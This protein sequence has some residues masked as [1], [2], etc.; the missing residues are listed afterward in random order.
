MQS[1]RDILFEQLERRLQGL[2]ES[3][4]GEAMRHD[5]LIRPLL[6]DPNGL[7][8][9]PNE[10]LSQQ[11]APFPRELAE[12]Y[13]WKGAVPRQRRPDIVVVPQGYSRTVAVVE[14]KKRHRSVESLRAISPQIKE[15]QYLHG[16]VWGLVTDGEKWLLWKN[17]EVFHSFGSLREL[18][19]SFD[20]LAQCIGRRQLMERLEKYGTTDMVV[21]RETPARVI[22]VG[23]PTVRQSPMTLASFLSTADLDVSGLM[24]HLVS[25][26]R[27]DITTGLTAVMNDDLRRGLTIACGAAVGNA[28]SGPVGMLEL[29]RHHGEE[30]GAD[31]RRDIADGFVRRYEFFNELGQRARVDAGSLSLAD[32][33]RVTMKWS[34][35]PGELPPRLKPFLTHALRFADLTPSE[36]SW[37]A[38]VTTD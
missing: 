4:D 22:V 38:K 25:S 1:E 37:V 29:A 13:V 21:F 35:N 7:G 19:Q 9:A 14:E 30:L 31:D 18:R 10:V 20:D 34:S 6:I 27:S 36:R 3:G 12:S 2:L 24:L 32:I 16:A 26:I 11:T 28:F 33:V 8:W 5:L 15:Y 23:V 17:N